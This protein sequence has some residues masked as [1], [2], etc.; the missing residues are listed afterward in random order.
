MAQP[1]KKEIAEFFD[2]EDAI[3]EQGYDEIL[4]AQ[5]A[6][7]REAGYSEQEA[8]EKA[9]AELVGLA[10]KEELMV[11]PSDVMEWVENNLVTPCLSPSSAPT[12]FAYSWVMHARKHKASM[13]K[14]IEYFQ[15]RAAKSEE[16]AISERMRD[17]GEKIVLLCRRIMRAA[18]EKE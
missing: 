14:L 11:L 8:M 3:Q 7:Y 4:K 10:T 16:T 9:Q 1:T 5:A 6:D 12:K 2:D 15:R 13:D 18:E 17:S